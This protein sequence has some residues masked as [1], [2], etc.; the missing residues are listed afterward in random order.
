MS[1]LAENL[2]NI[3]ISGNRDKLDVYDG[4]REQVMMAGYA[5]AEENTQKPWGAYVRLESDQT[6]EF[7]TDFFPHL[8][9]EQIRLGIDGAELSP[10]ILLVAPSQRLSLQY[11][12]RRAE[13]WRFLTDGAYVKSSDDEAGEVIQAKKG[14]V[15]QFAAQARHRLIG[16]TAT[17]TMVAEIWQHTN[18]ALL[19]D[20]DDIVR[21]DDDYKR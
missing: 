8:T 15:V 17:F 6:E 12:L 16:S 19:S 18:Q 7:I 4:I 1:V 10:K 11:H 9:I 14:E 20:E 13:I 2:G 21:L 5:I 3:V